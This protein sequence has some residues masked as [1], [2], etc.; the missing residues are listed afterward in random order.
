MN[1]IFK[2]LID[3]NIN[4]RTDEFKE[5]LKLADVNKLSTDQLW[6]VLILPSSQ[7]QS[8]YYILEYKLSYLLSNG[9]KSEIAYL[10]YLISYLLFMILTPVFARDLAIKYAEDSIK[11]ENISQ[12]KTWLES[13]RDET[14]IC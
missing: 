4:P 5:N 3:E 11:H 6:E 8:I 10:N 2:Q 1:K 9:T 14:N 7:Q 12:Y 13:I